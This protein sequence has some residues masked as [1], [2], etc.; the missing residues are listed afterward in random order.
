MAKQGLILE[1]IQ[2]RAFA[3]DAE[4]LT[5]IEAILA[6]YPGIDSHER[7]EVLQFLRKGPVRDR[8]LLTANRVVADSL[9]AFRRD[10]DRDLSWD[11]TE[12]FAVLA[13][14]A[15]AI[16]ISAWLLVSGS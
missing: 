11:P 4:R 8:S 6:R 16:A 3:V 7:E 13:I 10:N 5:E 12:V 2:R 1:K 9:D 15:I 14:V